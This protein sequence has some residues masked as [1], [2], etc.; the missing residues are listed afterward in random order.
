[1]KRI[2][3]VGDSISLYY[4][5][6]LSNFI[7]KKAELHTKEGR[8]QAFDNLDWPAGANGGDSSMVLSYLLKRDQS[9]TLDFDL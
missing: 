2:L 6:Y 1:M 7:N 8:Q 9:D 5:P 4:A 3:L